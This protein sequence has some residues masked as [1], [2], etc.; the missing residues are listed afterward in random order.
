MALII[1]AFLFYRRSRFT[2]NELY[3]TF[4]MVSLC[5]AVW[6]LGFLGLLNSDNTTA[7]ST[8]RWFMES[9]SILIPVFWLNFIY[10]FLGLK[11]YKKRELLI[12][13]CFGIFL[14]LLNFFDLFYPGIFSAGMSTK[15]IFRF[16]PNAGI[17]YYLYFFY[18]LLV[19]TQSLR[20]LLSHLGKATGFKLVQI[21]YLILAA[22]SGYGGGGMT[23][24]F[25]FNIG[26][27]PYGVIF[28]AL[29]PSIIAYTIVKYK[30][31]NIRLV[32]TRSILFSLLVLIVS[33]LFTSTLLFASKLASASTQN[34]ILI[35]TAVAIIVVLFLNPLRN[36]LAD[37]TDKVFFKRAV[38][39]QAVAQALSQMIAVTLERDELLHQFAIKLK[40]LLKLKNVTILFC[41]TEHQSCSLYYSQVVE[42]ERTN[43]HYGTQHPA[44]RTHLWNEYGNIIKF[45]TEYPVIKVREEE[46]RVADELKQG[47]YK[48]RL[49]K[50][51]Q[52]LEARAIAVVAPVIGSPREHAFIFL[53]DKISGDIYDNRDIRLLE[54]LQS[55]LAAA[56]EKSRLYEE[57]KEFNITLE[58]KVEEATLE[59]RDANK[60]L[61][62]L[63]KAKTLFLS[64]ASHQLRTPLTGIKGFLSMIL[65]GDFGETSEKI[66]DIISEVYANSNRLVRLVNTF[67]NVSRIEAGRLTLLKKEEDMARIA[68]KIINELQFAAHDRKLELQFECEKEPLMATVDVD[69]IEDVLIN[70]TDNAIKYTSAGTVTVRVKDLGARVRFEVQD[71]GQ[72]LSPSEKKTLFHKF[73][74]GDRALTI[75]TDGS[76]LGL[77]IAKRVVDLHKGEIGVE[78]PGV[79]KGSTFWFEVPKG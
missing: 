46:E 54:L 14:W 20:H 49:G 52:D 38:N 48:T 50:T 30:L 68:R 5:S 72:G 61:R 44:I 40:E 47:E 55:Q 70:F 27:P 36:F 34:I 29:Y 37:I 33:T 58:R 42:K 22:I 43:I 78:S 7:S 53:S 3:M 4:G 39:H 64:V 35:N 2:G 12:V 73:V 1:G 25:T 65:E 41:Q 28:F 15:G 19:V 74:R 59:L 66:K 21:R 77:Y 56:M 45:F 13:Y 57:V 76:G 8:W 79:G 51:V 62:Q 69:K 71:T 18:F 63:D 9:G 23:F 6:S 75:Q 31:M 24:L 60:R 17:G 26:I 32:V 67:L 11:K 10:S 16:Y